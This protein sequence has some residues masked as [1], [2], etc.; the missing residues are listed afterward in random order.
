MA[1]VLCVPLVLFVD[2]HVESS[3]WLVYYAYVYAS[4]F[5]SS[6]I[7]L[8][9]L[10]PEFPNKFSHKL[11]ISLH[12]IRLHLIRSIAAPQTVI[13]PIAVVTEYHSTKECEQLGLEPP[14]DPSFG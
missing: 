5:E 4:S 14:L 12:C 8:Q 10:F 7:L 13:G 6:K 9:G 2:S 3:I 1:S 11:F